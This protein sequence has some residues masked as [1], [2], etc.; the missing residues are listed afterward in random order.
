M[1]PNEKQAAL[2]VRFA[3]TSIDLAAAERHMVVVDL[4]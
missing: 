3:F 4:E 2:K 1:P